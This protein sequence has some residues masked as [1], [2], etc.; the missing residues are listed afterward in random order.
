M[1]LFFLTQSIQTTEKEKKDEE[2]INI[3]R[4]REPN[5]DKC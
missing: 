3:V 5:I 2:R 4:E 1:L